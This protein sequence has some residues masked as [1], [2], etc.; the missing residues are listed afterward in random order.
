MKNSE[1][2]A[3]LQGWLKRHPLRTPPAELQRKIRQEVMSR[4]RA[5]HASVRDRVLRWVLEPRWSFALGGALAAALVAA[6]LIFPARTADHAAAPAAQEVEQEAQL[7]LEVGE[8]AYLADLDLEG[9]LRDA[10]RLVLAEAVTTK[11]DPSWAEF[12]N[13]AEVLDLLEEDETQAAKTDRVTDEEL[14]E[15]L[16]RIDDAEMALS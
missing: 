5:E 6:I 14:L 15:E 1:W 3:W 11:P 10:D 9:E 8:T 7:L 4:I 16:K 13:N 12:E 2:D